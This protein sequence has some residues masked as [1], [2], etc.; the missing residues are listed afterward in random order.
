MEEKIDSFPSAN[1]HIPDKGAWIAREIFLGPKLCGID[2]NGN[3]DAAVFSRD[4]T[5][6]AN[7]GSMA[8]V[9]GPHGG[10]KNDGAALGS[11]DT[12]VGGGTDP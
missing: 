8:F 9:Q 12:P 6:A 10:N 2:E 5:G 4:T 1:C 7:E 3:N 11:R